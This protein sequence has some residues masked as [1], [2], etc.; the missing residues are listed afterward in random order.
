MIP[1][2][3]SKVIYALLGLVMPG[4]HEL[5]L[6]HKRGWYRLS[7]FLLSF[8]LIFAFGLGLFLLAFLWFMTLVDVISTLV[9]TR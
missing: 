8:P 7:A 5:Y 2:G 1:A 3:K 9:R 4:T 6:G